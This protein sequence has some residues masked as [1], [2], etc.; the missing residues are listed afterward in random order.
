MFSIVP[1]S[2]ES[3]HVTVENNLFMGSFWQAKLSI[4]GHSLF[5][6]HHDPH[7]REGSEVG[8]LLR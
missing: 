5:C 2:N 8:I 1:L 4:D 7:I 3:L 6:Y